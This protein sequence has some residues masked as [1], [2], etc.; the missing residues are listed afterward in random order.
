M[1]AYAKQKAQ[2]DGI[3][4]ISFLQAGFLSYEHNGSPL[5][6]IVSNLALHHLPD[7]WKM[8]GLNFAKEAQ[9]H[10]KEENSTFDWV[11]EEML[12]KS[13]FK[14]DIRRKDDFF[15]VYYCKKI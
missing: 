15:A 12:H 14:F 6:I 7:F 5:D 9:M 3:S 10:I 8:I 13:G 2:K 4:N 11:I 1:I